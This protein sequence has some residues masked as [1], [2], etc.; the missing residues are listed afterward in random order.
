MRLHSKS[1]PMHW[2]H[3]QVEQTHVDIWCQRTMTTG[4]HGQFY[5]GKHLV[6][7][8]SSVI[9]SSTGA[10]EKSAFEHWCQN[11]DTPAYSFPIPEIPLQGTSSWL[12]TL[13]I[14]IVIIINTVIINYDGDDWNG[15][16]LSRSDPNCCSSCPSPVSD[17]TQPSH[18]L[19][20]HTQSYILILNS[21]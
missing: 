7:G 10:P 16:N 2:M 4:L 13:I 15:S 12:F 17:Y 1:A 21:N 20:Q 3:Q 18:S 11:A 5:T 9:D 6:G 14:I 8:D 19:P